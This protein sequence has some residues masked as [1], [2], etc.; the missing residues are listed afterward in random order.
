MSTIHW[1]TSHSMIAPNLPE[2]GGYTGGLVGSVRSGGARLGLLGRGPPGGGGA[3]EMSPEGQHGEFCSGLDWGLGTFSRAC[4]VTIPV[5]D[6]GGSTWACLGCSGAVCLPRRSSFFS[7]ELLF[8][9]RG[10]YFIG[11]SILPSYRLPVL[12]LNNHIS[13]FL[14]YRCQ[15]RG[16][17]LCCTLLH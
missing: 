11:L 3:L 2:Q 16:R 7:H 12:A 15:K 4:H 1:T 6:M 9:Q 14:L 10:Y 17:W 13:L 8:F 5:E